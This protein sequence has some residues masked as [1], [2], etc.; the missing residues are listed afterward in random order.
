MVGQEPSEVNESIQGFTDY[1][2]RFIAFTL[3]SMR[4]R[5]DF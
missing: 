4:N 5:D 1:R 3:R 2:V